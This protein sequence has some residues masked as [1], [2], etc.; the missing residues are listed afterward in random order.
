L[1]HISDTLVNDIMN[2][3]TYPN[4]YAKWTYCQNLKKVTT[5]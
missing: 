4:R 2:R 3:D 1:W 5:K